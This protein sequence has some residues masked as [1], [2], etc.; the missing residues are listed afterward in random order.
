M[1]LIS[2]WKKKA[3]KPYITY[4]RSNLKSGKSK[5]ISVIKSTDGWV[6]NLSGDRLGYGFGTKGI[7]SKNIGIFKS[8]PKALAFAKAYM[9]RR[10]K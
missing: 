8:K 7:Y 4:G 9:K 2:D 10:V 1:G 3:E 5:D 6:V